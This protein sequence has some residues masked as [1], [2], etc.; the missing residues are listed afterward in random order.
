MNQPPT[1]EAQ[2]A[3]LDEF[4]DTLRKA[5][6]AVL[7]LDYD[8][9]LSPFRVERDQ[10]LPYPG[11]VDALARIASGGRTRLAVVSG[12]TVDTLLQLLDLPFPLEIWGT[13][14]AE[15]RQADGTYE[16]VTLSPSARVGLRQAE[17]FAR[18]LGYQGA[19]E[20]KPAGLALHWRGRT[21][22]WI[23][24]VRN[25]VL[26]EWKRIATRTPLEVLE[27]D[28]GVELRAQGFDK[29]MVVRQLLEEE[30]PGVPFAYLGDDL[31]D[32]DAFRVLRG[33]GLTV[34]V[35]ETFRPTEAELWLRPPEDLLEFLK[36]WAEATGAKA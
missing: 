14:G 4:F 19:L 36:R 26:A 18:L 12:R 1:P 5:P 32:E 6:R 15:H 27:F 17:D 25:N 29:G 22:G 2:K 24:G 7:L 28:G 8:G 9:T 13:H 30:S 23:R 3:L 16:H 10:A 34:L 31:T 20:A 21:E 11:V 33:R 35:R